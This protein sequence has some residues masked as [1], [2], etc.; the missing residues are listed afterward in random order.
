MCQ[1]FL[2]AIFAVLTCGAVAGAQPIF[3]VVSGVVEDP[4]HRPV[5]QAQVTLRD[6][7]SGS[8]VQ[9]ETDV[10]G[11]FSMP[12]VPVGEYT[13]SV[14]K[15]GFR[16]VEQRVVVRSGTVTPMTVA[17]PL[18]D[19]SETVDVVAN[20]GTINTRSTTTQSLVV[21]DEIEHTPG[22][23]RTNS[24][25]VVTQ[26]VP[27]SYVIHDQ[28]HIRGGHQVSWLVDGVPVPNT[29]IATT[30]GPQFDPKDI[31]T[32]EMQRGGYSADFGERTFGV[33]NVVPRSGF[34]RN[35]EAEV[36]ASYGNFHE[37]NDQVSVG[38]HTERFA[39]YA[40]L[41]AN[42]TDLGLQTPVPEN[43]HN[44]AAGVGGFGSLIFKSTPTDQF[45]LV[46]S[47]RGDR[48][49]VPNTPDDQVAGIDDVQRERDG[50]INASWLRTIGSQ[51]FL[52]LS[53]FYHYNRAALDGGPND[54][55]ITTDHRSSQYIGAQATIAV[56]HGAHTARVGAYG[57]Y[58]RDQV[59]FGLASPDE[60]ASQ[61]QTPTGH[62]EVVFAEDQIAA[63]G[64]LT[65]NAGVR[66]THFSGELSEG[67]VA[68]RLGV[69]VRLPW[70]WAAR[71]YYGRFYQP[72]P[73][74]TVSDQVLAATGEEELG[75]LPLKGERD[76]QYEVGLAI[77]VRE[78]AVDVDYF[79]THATNFF[80]H[81]PIGNSNIFIPVT[82][83]EARIRGLEATLRSPRLGRT[84]AHAA[85]AY[86]FV[87]GRGGVSGGLTD[88]APPSDDWFFLDHDQRHT[89]S[90]GVDVDLPARAW[91]S[92]SAGFGSGFLEGDGPDHKPAHV[93]FNL[94]AGKSFGKQ[95][96]VVLSGL[97][98]ADTHFLLD[99]SNT[100][101]GTHY[102][103]PRQVAAGVRY[104]FHY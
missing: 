51:A 38:D 76:D 78:W 54:P 83:D 53:P 104:R 77:P 88:F 3:G 29:N 14:V 72:P 17:L 93:V 96:S 97:N 89:L 8:L 13:A 42:R 94:Q 12:A 5:A 15:Q 52:T 101:G 27:S 65:V 57:F 34:E 4:Q 98:V 99:D 18:G 71:A 1:K 61:E 102:N 79:H 7:M 100:F 28:L 62:L 36:V 11:R 81:E 46:G 32:I 16:T 21:R 85:Y 25:D 50:F 37:T 45:R 70:Q 19:V 10:A 2:L 24:L 47:L 86:Q 95:W 41:N 30:V 44:D 67:A 49:Q 60:S 74:T 31:E 35:R 40:S 73:L 23:L 20:G 66:A 64:W 26:F 55:L 87:E 33:F 58:Q 90:G 80:D 68:P 22:A 59:F 6:P 9:A 91:A 39:Y 69:A 43:L 82:I 92:V 56:S 75:F 48:Y 103:S 84:R 63:T